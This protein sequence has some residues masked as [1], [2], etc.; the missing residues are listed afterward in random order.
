MRSNELAGRLA[1]LSVG[2]VALSASAGGQSL[3]NSAQYCETTYQVNCSSP[4]SETVTN[5]TPI[6]ISGTVGG[7]SSTV[8]YNAFS[9]QSA[10]TIE[11][12]S[13]GN[14]LVSGGS[15]LQA[16]S[17]SATFSGGTGTGSGV[18][19]LTGTLSAASVGN[20]T[21]N[22]G[23]SLT[24]TDGSSGTSYGGAYALQ[25]SVY[26]NN[27]D[28]TVSNLSCSQSSACTYNSAAQQLLVPFTFTYGATTTIQVTI[29]A[30]SDVLNPPAPASSSAAANLKLSF[31]LP[32]CT[33]ISAQSGTA[34]AVS[35]SGGNCGSSAPATDGPL[36]LWSIV[37]LGGMLL[38]VGTRRANRPA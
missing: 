11:A 27:N 26:L 38:V 17:D 9:A 35:S 4:E 23:E 15:V 13:N 34:Y 20:V 5:S 16:T 37:A 29:Q 1:F 3:S 36:P 7:V 33:T 31:V 10:S 28:A 2:V 6:V 24:V 30:N 32:A 22:S 12:L 8:N 19:I 25:S 14:Y 21:T 18:A